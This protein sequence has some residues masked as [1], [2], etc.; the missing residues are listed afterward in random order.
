MRKARKTVRKLSELDL[1]SRPGWAW[2]MRVSG[3]VGAVSLPFALLW[4]V[5]A[6]KP[7]SIGV[8]AVSGLVFFVALSKA[9]PKSNGMLKNDGPWTLD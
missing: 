8:L 7:L 4:E 3:A 2:A 5:T 6:F 9:R 1:E